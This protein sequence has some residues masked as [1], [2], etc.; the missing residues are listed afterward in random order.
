MD[1]FSFENLQAFQ[2]A[3]KL[4]TSVYRIAKKFPDD[5]RYAITQQLRRA[6]VSVP[7]NLAEGSGRV[8]IKE[9]VNFISIAFGSLAEAFCQLHIAT[10]LGYMTQTELDCLRKEFTTVSRLMNGLKKSFQRKLE[11]QSTTITPKPYHIP[12]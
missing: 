5:E 12:K 4:V 10:A 8:S 6:I 1:F 2:E 9:K 7:S 3:E 11:P